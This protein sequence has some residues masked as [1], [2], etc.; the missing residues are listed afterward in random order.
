VREHT[1]QRA[2]DANRRIISVEVQTAF[3]V[4]QRREAA[5]IELERNALPGLDDNEA[6]ARRSYEAGLL[7]L[8]EWLLI[9]REILETK[10]EHLTRLLEAA[11]AG[12]ELEAS[13]GVL[14]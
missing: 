2:L 7:S 13:A 8:A 4:Y 12:V 3:A 1:A 14:Q 5:A 10:G 11:V 6:L 9:R